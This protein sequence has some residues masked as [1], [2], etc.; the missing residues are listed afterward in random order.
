MLVGREDRGRKLVRTTLAMV[1]RF[2]VEIKHK[3]LILEAVT[4]YSKR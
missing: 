1:A 3:R 2:V 4:T